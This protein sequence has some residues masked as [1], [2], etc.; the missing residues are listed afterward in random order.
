VSKDDLC[1]IGEAPR[2]GKTRL[3]GVISPKSEGNSS[4]D[5]R[6]PHSAW[7]PAL[8]LCLLAAGA[9]FAAARFCLRRIR[10]PI[11]PPPLTGLDVAL[12]A[13]SVS[14]LSGCNAGPAI[15]EFVSPASRSVAPV[16]CAQSDMPEDLAQPSTGGAGRMAANEA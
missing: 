3:G 15:G 4:Q 7:L 9:G 5:F 16:S 14:Q 1:M 2:F 10:R 13:A 6:A 8:G 11:A 12:L